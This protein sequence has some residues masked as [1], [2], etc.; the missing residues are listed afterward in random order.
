[1]SSGAGHRGSAVLS[2]W[3][4]FMAPPT[5]S[6]TTMVLEPGAGGTDAEMI[7]AVGDGLWLDQLGYAFPD[8]I[9]STFGGEVR[10]GYVVERGKLTNPVRGGTVGGV[11]LGGPGEASM[12]QSVR[13]IGSHPSLVGR[14]SAPTI[15]VGSLTVAGA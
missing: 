6:P 9:S 15:S 7:E 10:L 3:F 4:H 8:A 5:P 12:L 2:P 13:S 11:V 14:L 1:Q